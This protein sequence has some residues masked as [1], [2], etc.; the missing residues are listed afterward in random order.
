MD[1]IVAKSK[2]NIFPI[3]L[4]VSIGVGMIIAGE[5]L[6]PIWVSIFLF[7]LALFFFVSIRTVTVT[8]NELTFKLIWRKS[9]SIKKEDI[10]SIKGFYVGNT[11]A[12]R[13]RMIGQNYWIQIQGK[14]KKDVFF[15]T[16][17]GE[18]DFDKICQLLLDHYSHLFEEETSSEEK[19]K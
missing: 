19:K 15:I 13:A 8:P 14:N 7:G 11:A 10:E 18:R 16:E 9:K 5:S 2:N 17:K 3:V 4:C 12:H 6:F 1:K